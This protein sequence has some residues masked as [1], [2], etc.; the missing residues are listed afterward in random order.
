V[1]TVAGTGKE[2]FADGLLKSAQFNYPVGI[3]LD[4][5]EQSLFVCDFGNS[6]LRRVSFLQGK[7]FILSHYLL[8]SFSFLSQFL[9]CNLLFKDT[10]IT[11]CQIIKP[12]FT[13]ITASQSVLISSASHTI[14]SH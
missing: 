7:L 2:G 6:K 1:S 11:I 9:L 10:V 12:I 4:E 13:V 3:Y 8:S 14:S 5:I